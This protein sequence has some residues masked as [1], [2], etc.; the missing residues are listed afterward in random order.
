MIHLLKPNS[1]NLASLHRN[2]DFAQLRKQNSKTLFEIG[3]NL[4]KV[5][6]GAKSLK[7][8]GV[9]VV[10]LGANDILD[11]KEHLVLGLVWQLVRAHMLQDVN[12]ISHPQLIRLLNKG[13]T[14]KELFAMNPEM[15]L[16][17]WFN[18]H[19]RRAGAS[20]IKNFSSDLADS[21]KYALL[22]KQICPM[23]IDLALLDSLKSKTDNIAKAEIILKV[24]DSFGCKRFVTP[25]DV[26]GGNSRLNLAFTAGLFNKF[27]GIFLPTDEEIRELYKRL[28]TLEMENA[29]LKQDLAA[30]EDAL[31]SVALQIDQLSL[32]M[33]E[34]DASMKAK[35]V[36]ELKAALAEKDREMK[37]KEEQY[38]KILKDNTDSY[39]KEQKLREA[40]HQSIV[41]ALQAK[42]KQQLYQLERDYDKKKQAIATALVHMQRSLDDFLSQTTEDQPEM[43]MSLKEAQDKIESA[44]KVLQEQMVKVLELYYNKTDDLKEM[45]TKYDHIR[46]VHEVY[47]EKILEFAETHRP[48]KG[49]SRLG[50][51]NVFGTRK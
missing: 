32:E 27:I 39:S 7:S 8:Q 50:L 30:K 46:S 38:Q 12:L 42:N 21:E 18:F 22:L 44:P 28:E 20:E 4:N 6:E 23:S 41:E 43:A 3:E 15:V 5:V 51:N 9:V 24:V 16:M 37:E 31:N 2:I 11:K 40:E 14:L 19:M 13:E 48:A 47:G 17:R 26:A 45:K 35:M 33:N 36:T 10:N 25:K 1:I 29:S 34:R 49:K